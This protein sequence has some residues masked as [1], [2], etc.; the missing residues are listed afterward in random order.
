MPADN[1]GF[2]YKAAAEL[3]LGR[4]PRGGTRIPKY[5]RFARSADAI[6]F[7]IEKLANEVL[8]STYLEVDEKRYDGKGIR[9]LYDEAGFTAKGSAAKSSAAKGSLAKSS[10]AKSSPAKNADADSFA[11]KSLPKVA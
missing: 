2:D 7:A 5:M 6:R 8:I 3:F 1:V 4:N 10:G 9:Q 11:T